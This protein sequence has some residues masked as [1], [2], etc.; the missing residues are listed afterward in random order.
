MLARVCHRQTGEAIS[1]LALD[2]KIFALHSSSLKGFGRV[3]GL[4]V[5]FT[6]E[7][8]HA[9]HVCTRHT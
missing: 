8:V 2:P 6:G 4:K 5:Y 7:V 1:L 9:W 3:S